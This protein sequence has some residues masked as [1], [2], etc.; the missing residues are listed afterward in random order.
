[1]HWQEPGIKIVA[2]VMD[3]PLREVL[4]HTGLWATGKAGD[5]VYE[6]NILFTRKVPALL[7]LTV[8]LEVKFSFGKQD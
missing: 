4:A 3:W 8:T 5:S 1:M 2:C 6:K 7:I